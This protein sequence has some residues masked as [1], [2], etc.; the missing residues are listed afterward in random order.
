MVRGSVHMQKVFHLT[1][2]CQI[3]IDR[4]L[5]TLHEPYLLAHANRKKKVS[6]AHPLHKPCPSFPCPVVPKPASSSLFPQTKNALA[7]QLRF[8]LTVFLSELCHSAKLLGILVLMLSLAPGPQQEGLQ[9]SIEDTSKFEGLAQW[10]KMPTSAFTIW[11]LKRFVR[12]IIYFKK[13][14]ITMQGTGSK[15]ILFWKIKTDFQIS[16]Q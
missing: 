13:S 16:L 14:T 3:A 6:P 1:I 4:Q 11:K 5:E 8:L 2:E 10:N 7:A 12:P 15:L 9:W